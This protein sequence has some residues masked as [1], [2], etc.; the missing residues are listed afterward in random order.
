MQVLCACLSTAAEG[1]EQLRR[2]LWAALLRAV[3][4]LSRFGRSETYHS[5][6]YI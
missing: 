3:N 5:C 1:A 4:E 2:S 6:S